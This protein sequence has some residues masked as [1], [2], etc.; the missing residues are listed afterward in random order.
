MLISFTLSMP[1]HPSWN[2]EWVK[3]KPYQKV[4]DIGEAKGEALC[5]IGLFEY[6]STVPV[7]VRVKEVDIA[8]AAEITRRADFNGD[9]WMVDSI[10]EHGQILDGRGVPSED[11]FLFSGPMTVS[12]LIARLSKYDG[13][14]KIRAM[15]VSDASLIDWPAKELTAFNRWNFR[16]ES[17]VET[18]EAQVAK[19]VRIDKPEPTGTE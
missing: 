16:L 4:A 13:E 15:I 6:G 19:S 5:K 2:R 14:V 18:I 8:E 12:E 10:I 9:D 1:G 17:P 11:A 3:G 7:I